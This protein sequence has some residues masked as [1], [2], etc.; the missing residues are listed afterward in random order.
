MLVLEISKGELKKES[1]SFRLRKSLNAKPVNHRDGLGAD[2]QT[3]P[4]K[5]KCK[6]HIPCQV[7]K[8]KRKDKKKGSLSIFS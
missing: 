8:A 2:K 5:F 6:F 4:R 3:N 7:K 1:F